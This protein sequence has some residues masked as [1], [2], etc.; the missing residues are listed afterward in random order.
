MPTHR[1]S[2]TS[3]LLL[4][5]VGGQLVV[6]PMIVQWANAN[7]FAFDRD[8]LFRMAWL[9][10]ATI[11]VGLIAFSPLIEQ[12]PRHGVFAFLAI[13]PLLWAALRYSQ[14]DTATVTVV[15]STFAIWGT[16]TNN[17]P[18]AGANLND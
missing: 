10:V 4:G 9:M 13:G 16:L 5:D 6:A 14:R 1:S 17:G 11:A 2:G 7:V 8:E 18:F 12:T 3:G 15:L